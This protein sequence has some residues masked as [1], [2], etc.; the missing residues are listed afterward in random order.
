MGASAAAPAAGDLAGV[1]LPAG[2]RLCVVL[3]ARAN[4][5]EVRCQGEARIRALPLRDLESIAALPADWPIDQRPQSCEQPPWLCTPLRL[6]ASTPAARELAAA[7]LLLSEGS[8]GLP[9]RAPKSAGADSGLSLADFADLV[10][11]GED[12]CRRAACWLWLESGQTLFRRRQQS[13]EARPLEDLRQLRLERRR[14]QLQEQ[15]QQRWCQTLQA[16]RPIQ[17]ELLETSERED[18]DRLRQWAAGDTDTP[19]PE[20]LLRLLRDSHCGADSGSIRHLLVDLGQWERHHL[21]SLESSPW[22]E[23][24]RPELLAEAQRLLQSAAEA[25][26]G[27]DQRLDLTAQRVITIDDDDTLEIDDG[28]GLEWLQ[29]EP[30]RLW[31][32]IADPGRLIEAGSPLDREAARR[33]SSLYLA[34]GTLPMFPSALAHGPMSLRAGERCAALSLWVDLDPEGSVVADGIVRSW[35]RPTYRLSY[36]D[37]DALLELAPPQERDLLRLAELLTGRRRWRLERGALQF[38]DPEGRIRARPG[39]AP[40]LQAELEVIEPSPSRQLVA[41]AMVLAGALV[42]ERGLREGLALPFRSQLPGELPPP[43]ELA[44]LPAGPVRHAA[45]KRCLSRGL[46]G[47]SAA[48]HFS[49]GLAAYV[50]ATSPIRRYGDLLV[51]RQLCALLEGR[52]PLSEPQLAEQLRELEPA[53]RQGVQIQRDDQRH[54]LQ[55]WFEQQPRHPLVG[56]FLRWLRPDQQLAL[57]WLEELCQSLPCHGPARSEP[58]S[59]LLV[60]VVEVDS[61]RDRLQLEATL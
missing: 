50:Q 59:R 20:P 13:V 15:R 43:S 45:I 31:I 39:D 35:I 2:P 9:A 32:H 14:R 19:L 58:G 10:A 54:W 25:M 30:P 12:P 21:P 37:A 3:S 4:R 42:A 51:Q 56:L 16:R 28:L 29:P 49:L 48:P 11:D 18:L 33:A 17:P 34:R 52:S 1:L 40:T 47:T 44:A 24:F 22:R 41:E 38:D 26:P 8:P 61:L 5:V 27:D 57:V 7:W 36:A 46:V 55:V 53:L 23:G 60:R 6:A